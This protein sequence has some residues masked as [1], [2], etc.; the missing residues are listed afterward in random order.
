[1][2][3]RQKAF[4]SLRELK[5]CHHNRK[6]QPL[7]YL[8]CNNTAARNFTTNTAPSYRIQNLPTTCNA[9]Y[10]LHDYFVP[11]YRAKYSAQPTVQTNRKNCAGLHHLT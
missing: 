6:F 8:T 2:V 10:L 7:D 9:E 3:N 5:F 11:W 1:M 4:L